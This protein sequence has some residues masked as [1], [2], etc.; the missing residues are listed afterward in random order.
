MENKVR[1][2]GKDTVGRINLGR[3]KSIEEYYEKVKKGLYVDYTDTFLRVDFKNGHHE[4]ICPIRLE[5]A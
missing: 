2:C 4:H 1:I 3:N 5:R